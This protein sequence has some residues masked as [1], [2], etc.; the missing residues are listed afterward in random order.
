MPKIAYAVPSRMS[1]ETAALIARVADNWESV[2][3]FLNREE[4]E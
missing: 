4:E 3:D 1:K 2:Q